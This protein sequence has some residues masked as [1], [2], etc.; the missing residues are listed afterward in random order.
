MK[1]SPFILI[2]MSVQVLLIFFLIYKNSRI[3]ELSFQKQQQEKVKNALLKE[4]ERLQQKLC[5]AQDK[6]A[7]K[8]Y[9]Q[10]EL[11]MEKINPKAIKSLSI[12][13]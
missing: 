12:E 1:R 4:K 7:I 6:T 2:V 10:H 9:A 8:H 11:K 13:S 5:M 3:V